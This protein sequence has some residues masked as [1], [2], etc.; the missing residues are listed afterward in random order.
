MLYNL[1]LKSKTS[2]LDRM[3]T[4]SSNEEILAGTR[5]IVPFG[6]GDTKTIGIVIEKNIEDS[7]AFEAKEIIEILDNKPIV[8][9]ELLKV[10]FYMVKNNISDYSSAINA[11]LPPG[12][13]DKVEEFYI[14]NKI[15]SDDELL[16]FLESEKTFKQI[17][18][19]FNGK[20][21]KSFLNSMVSKN[22]IESFFDL[23]V[24]QVS[25]M[26]KLLP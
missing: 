5:V 26:K 3:F 14:N 9:D 12:S 23:K 17:L 20:Y 16:T 24:R 8:S 18:N 6:K 25:N 1:I 13:I 15:N 7:F 21:T 22:Q 10:A 2:F 19:K 11:I 4:Y